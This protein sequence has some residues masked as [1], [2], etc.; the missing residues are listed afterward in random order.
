[1]T[2]FK[3]YQLWWSRDDIPR[4]PMM[5][6]SPP[7]FAYTPT[8]QGVLSWLKAPLAIVVRILV[9]TSISSIIFKHHTNTL[10]NSVLL[11]KYISYIITLFRPK[12]SLWYTELAHSFDRRMYSE[13]K[14]IYGLIYGKISRSYK[15]MKW[16]DVLNRKRK[17]FYTQMYVWKC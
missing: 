7:L 13:W 5:L 1:M 14:I 10:C 4:K 8:Q 12:F 17:V 16:Q 15:P 9:L 11:V 3:T 6:W 2:I